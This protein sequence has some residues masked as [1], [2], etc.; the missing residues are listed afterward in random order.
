MTANSGSGT[1]SRFPNAASWGV[2][3]VLRCEGA[4]GGGVITMRGM[5][6]SG[7]RMGMATALVPGCGGNL[8]TG[9]SAARGLRGDPLRH[10]LPLRQV[11]RSSRYRKLGTCSG[12][13]VG[14]RKGKSSSIGMVVVSAVPSTVQVVRRG[15]GRLA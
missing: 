6:L 2:G 8:R 4:A 14:E 7:T 5:L 13:H 9:V 3:T 10:A 12:R 15:E 1:V 11:L